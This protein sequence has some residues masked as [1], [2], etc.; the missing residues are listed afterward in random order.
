MRPPPAPGLAGRS[1]PERWKEVLKLSS[2][3][4]GTM[5]GPGRSGG[6]C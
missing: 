1:L 5:A 3:G 6:H 2:D 4:R